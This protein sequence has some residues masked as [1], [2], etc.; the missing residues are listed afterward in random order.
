MLVDG[1]ISEHV[2]ADDRGLA[3]G[4]G[5][6]ETLAVI[7]GR[8]RFWQGH[9]DRLFGGCEKLGLQMPRQ[10]VLLREV[11]T[12]A[13]GKARCVVKIIVT[14]GSG[15]RGYTPPQQQLACRIVSVHEWPDNIPDLREQG[16]SARICELRLSLQPA[17]AGIKHLC[18]LEQVLASR[19]IS[20]FPEPEGV[21]LDQDGHVVSLLSANLF[22][23][24]KQRLFTPRMDRCGVRGVL[25]QVLLEEF[26][27]RCEVRRIGVEMLAE[28]DEVFA[29]N[30]VRAIFP[31]TRIDEIQ[32]PI[33]PVTRE[34]QD[35]FDRLAKDS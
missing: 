18:R 21:L 16:V 24:S 25:R 14:R 30:A 20:G 33:G 9:M 32:F 2:R 7:A 17:L 26:Q 3:Y 13:A 19:E 29:C 34:I 8:P 6:F 35:W 27:G 22:L 1:V 31:V 28:V 23:V 11:Q 12:V 4:D 15:G 5:L 10:D